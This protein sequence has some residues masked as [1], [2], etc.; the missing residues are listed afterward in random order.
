[1]KSIVFFV[2]SL[3]L[4]VILKVTNL[5]IGHDI[6]A[7]LISSLIIAIVMPIF[8][9][10]LREVKYVEKK[11]LLQAFIAG[12]IYGAFKYSKLLFIGGEGFETSDLIDNWTTTV[13]V[14]CFLFPIIEEFIFRGILFDEIREKFGNKITIFITSVGFLYLH[15][16]NFSE[17]SQ[18]L[19][20]LFM[21]PGVAIYVYFKIKTNNF[22]VSAIAHS[23]H[24]SVVLFLFAFS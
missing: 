9:S 20:T 13:L 23:T 19:S 10:S 6:F 24:N 14:I 1:M 21:L 22:F 7:I 5:D 3:T 17:D 16:S 15:L 11:I 12:L 2:C 4:F 18:V 8:R